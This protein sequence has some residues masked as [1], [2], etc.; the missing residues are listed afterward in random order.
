MISIL[1]STYRRLWVMSE[2]YKF[3][4]PMG[5][6]F[7]TLTTIGWVDVFTRPELK[8]VVVKS[9]K[10]C[11]KEKGLLIHAWCLMTSH[12]HKMI[13]TDPDSYRENRC[14]AFCE[15]LRNSRHV[16]YFN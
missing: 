12:L 3:R 5:V 10:H 15:T 16:K 8:H 7:V 4:D 1:D 6:Y 13:S 2:K 9:L 14:Q 11:Q